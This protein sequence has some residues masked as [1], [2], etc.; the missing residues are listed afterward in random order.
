MPC[1]AQVFRPVTKEQF[2]AIVAKAAAADINLVGN[3]GAVSHSGF[4]IAW[5]FEPTSSSWTI[6]CTSHPF[7]ISCGT[8]NARIHDIVDGTQH[9]VGSLPANTQP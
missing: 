4:T 1:A 5:T 7:V 9:S 3:T 8:V 2:G 6:Q